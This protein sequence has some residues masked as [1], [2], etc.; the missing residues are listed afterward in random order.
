MSAERF[1]EHINFLEGYKVRIKELHWNADKLSTH[2]LCDEIAEHTLGYQ[3]SIAEEGFVLF[4]K[5]EPGVFWP[6]EPSSTTINNLLNE[7]S[8][9]LILFKS[10]LRDDSGKFDGMLGNCDEFLHI[11]NKF[12]YLTEMD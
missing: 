6:L 2:D 8:N 12:K 10:E 1:L 11:L 7:M 5:F 3:D 9:E 4:G